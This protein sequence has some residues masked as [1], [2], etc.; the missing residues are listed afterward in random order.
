M[1]TKNN[2]DFALLLTRPV[3]TSGGIRHSTPPPPSMLRNPDGC[4]NVGTALPSCGSVN[5]GVSLRRYMGA[6]KTCSDLIS[7]PRRA[8]CDR[9]PECFARWAPPSYAQI[10]Q[11]VPLL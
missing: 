3:S 4:S 5:D 11:G 9:T 8:E 6:K 1:V 10:A 2:L 7:P